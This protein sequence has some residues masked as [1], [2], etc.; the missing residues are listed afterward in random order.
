LGLV[1]T[2]EARLYS[3]KLVNPA[4]E[5]RVVDNHQGY[6]KPTFF[7]LIH[8]E[9]CIAKLHQANKNHSGNMS[10]F[11]E[12]S[13]DA[14]MKF[15]FSTSDTPAI[16]PTSTYQSFFDEVFEMKH[17]SIQRSIQSSQQATPPIQRT[18]S[19]GIMA[20]PPLP[21]PPPIRRILSFHDDDDYDEADEL[22]HSQLLDGYI[23]DSLFLPMSFMTDAEPIESSFASS[24]STFIRPRILSFSSQ[25]E[26]NHLVGWDGMASTSPAS[27]ELDDNDM[28]VS[29]SHSASELSTLSTLAG[30]SSS[31]LDEL[32]TCHEN[33]NKYVNPFSSWNQKNIHISGMAAT[34]PSSP[35]PPSIMHLPEFPP[36]D[37]NG[38]FRSRIQLIPRHNH[39]NALLMKY[40][41]IINL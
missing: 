17:L 29:C 38:M 11:E 36:A 6:Q 33:E 14:A 18:E 10:S 21:P 39:D 8:K 31:S 28:E 19:N 34:S 7:E 40:S 41:G 4:A 37:I 15:D 3:N 25:S 13:L 26:I 1:I 24:P 22:Q 20:I 23:P 30:T 5:N 12:S 35:P 9:T 2:S 32:D 16:S 27:Y